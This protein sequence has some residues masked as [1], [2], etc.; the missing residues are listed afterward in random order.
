MA[1][2]KELRRLGQSFK[3]LENEVLGVLLYGSKAKGKETPRSDTDICI[4]LGEKELEKIKNIL[5]E[6]WHEVNVEALNLDVKVFEELPLHLKANIIKHHEILLSRSKPGL[7]EY[8]YKFRKL[9][10]DQKHRQTLTKEE[11]RRILATH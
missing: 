10:K 6:I 8:F 2:E 4:V 5:K 11:K 9:W 3:F 7:Y 1:K